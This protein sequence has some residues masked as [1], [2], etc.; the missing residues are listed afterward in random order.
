MQW[1]GA[2]FPW[3]YLSSM[4]VLEGRWKHLFL[5][6]FWDGK[7]RRGRREKLRL[8]GPLRG[9]KSIKKDSRLGRQDFNN[10]GHETALTAIAGPPQSPW[11]RSPIGSRRQASVLP[12]DWPPQTRESSPVRH[13]LPQPS[14]RR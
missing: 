4:G 7:Q 6:G 11:L 10:L 9:R 12:S 1:A 13:D 2:L 14:R 3:P 5:A 8:K